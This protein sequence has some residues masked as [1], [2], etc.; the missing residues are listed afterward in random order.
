VGDTLRPI[1]GDTT[2]GVVVV[3]VDGSIIDD[4]DDYCECVS[5]WV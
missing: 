4:Y 2:G 1:S 5:E 3:V